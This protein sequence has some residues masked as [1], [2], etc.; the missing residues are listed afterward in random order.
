[1]RIHLHNTCKRMRVCTWYMSEDV[2][3]V[4]GYGC[5]IHSVSQRQD[6]ILIVNM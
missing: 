3:I 5:V 6:N 4:S 2:N 1:M